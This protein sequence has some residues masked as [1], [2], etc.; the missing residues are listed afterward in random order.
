[1]TATVPSELDDIQPLPWSEVRLM[2]DP[3]A[4]PEDDDESYWQ[5]IMAEADVAE[6]TASTAPVAR[7]PDD[8]WSARP[9]FGLIQQYARARRV[10]PWAVLGVTLVRIVVAVPPF[11]ALPPLTG[12]AASLNMF[13]GIVGPSGGGKGGAEAVASEVVDIQ[14]HMPT[15]TGPGSGEGLAHMFMRRV[16]DPNDKKTMILEQHTTSVLLSV[17]EI[18]T[19]AALTDRRAS[20]MLPELRKAWS[21]ETLGFAYADPDKRLPVPAHKYR[22]GLTVGIQPARAGGLL[23]DADG[24]TPQRFLWLPVDDPEAPDIAPETPLPWQWQFPRWPVSEGRGLTFLPVCQTAR[25]AVDQ[26]RLAR[27]RGLGEALNGHAL[28]ARLKVA[29]AIGVLNGR[30]EV[31]EDDWALAEL[32]MIKSDETRAGVVEAL[33]QSRASENRRR[34]EA[35]ADRAVVVDDRLAEAAVKRVCRTIVRVLGGADGQEMSHTEVRRKVAMRDRLHFE[36]AIESLI[37]TGQIVVEKTAAG[38]RYQLQRSA[39]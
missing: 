39:P 34:G 11:I 38:H 7:N 20:T 31:S 2:L 15:P 13:V 27:L 22:L 37:T 5:A 4:A 3:D 18:D 8:I 23:A 19:L 14:V 17:A 30:A 1:M 16:R 12:G 32:V 36:T 24:G 28:L 25:D 10:S 26:A 21:G 6:P 33:S 9:E 29:A 35:D